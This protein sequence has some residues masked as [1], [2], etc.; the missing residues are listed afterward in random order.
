MNAITIIEA[1]P[2]AALESW[3]AKGRALVD[4]RRD[5]DWRLADWMAEGKN[6]GH[7]SQAKFDF[8]SE[9]RDL[10]DSLIFELGQAAF[11]RRRV[12]DGPLTDGGHGPQHGFKLLGLGPQGNR[13]DFGR[14]LRSRGFFLCPAAAT[15][16]QQRKHARDQGH[17]GPRD[18]H[19]GV[20]PD[21]AMASPP[22][23]SCRS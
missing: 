22:S 9:N 4:Q 1:A 3:V 2:S 6:A 18:D 23:S 17:P 10:K 19:P 12:L 11:E 20:P 7:L 15:M 8:L 13:T 21:V 16:Q 14:R 5:I